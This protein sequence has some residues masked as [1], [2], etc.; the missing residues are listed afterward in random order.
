MVCTDSE[1]VRGE[2]PSQLSSRSQFTDSTFRNERT[3]K[4]KSPNLSGGTTHCSPSRIQSSIFLIIIHLPVNAT[5]R[6]SILLKCK[7]PPSDTTARRHRQIFSM[8]NGK[9]NLSATRSNPSLMSKHVFLTAW[10]LLSVLLFALHLPRSTFAV[11]YLSGLSSTSFTPNNISEIRRL[12]RRQGDIT[13][14]EGSCGT[15]LKICGGRCVPFDWIPCLGM[16]IPPRFDCC[17]NGYCCRGKCTSDGE[18]CDSSDACPGLQP[19]CCVNVY[20][21]TYNC[22]R[23]G[24]ICGQVSGGWPYCS[25]GECLKFVYQ[26][27]VSYQQKLMLP[28]LQTC[29]RLFWLTG[30]CLTECAPGYAPYKGGCLKQDPCSGIDCGSHSSCSSGSCY[31]DSG[32]QSSSGRDCQKIDPCS[33]IQCGAYSS[34]S[35][36]VCT[37]STGYKS[38]SGDGKNCYKPDPCEGITCGDYSSCSNAVCSCNSGYKSSSGD[39]K[40]CYLPNPCDGISCGDYSTCSGGKCTCNAGY[41]SSSG[42]GKSCTKVDP[43]SGINCGSF[44][45][46]VNGVCSCQSGYTSDAN[47]G[48][49]CYLADKCAGVTCGSFSSCYNGAC[50][51]QTG[52]Q[53]PDGSGQNCV[54]IDKCAG[55][56]CG[57]HSTCSGGVCS[58]ETGFVSD[59]NGR[60]CY[61]ESPP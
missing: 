40:N 28:L 39:G 29:V 18:H 13:P 24:Y 58:C 5:G 45:S 10:R 21:D 61:C 11:P 15:H 54:A 25:A 49:N 34:C 51:C 42:D 17:K 56:S 9:T 46:C 20:S 12:H 30:V 59:N 27:V 2:C 7:Q 22:G 31:C 32:Y 36:A 38:S 44:S 41:S 37:C 14:F 23:E 35:N 26:E 60:D 57:T 47:S 6:R 3:Q 50:S 4:C 16:C 48:K 19:G 33:S 53:S 52:Y 55:I 43:C 8:P 1:L